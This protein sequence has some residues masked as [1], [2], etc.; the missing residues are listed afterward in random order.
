MKRDRRLSILYEDDE[1]LVVD[2]PAGVLTIPSHPTRAPYEDTVLR[3]VREYVSR[4]R[5][6]RPYVGVLHRLDRDTSGALAL[7]L[8]REAH[9]AG[10]ALFSAHQFERHYLAIVHGVPAPEKGTIRAPISSRYISGRRGVARPGRDARDAVTH[11]TVLED[12]GRVSLVA[13]ELGTGRQHQIRAHLEHLGHPLLGERVYSGEGKARIKAPRQML[14]AW[15]L[16]F[17]HPLRSVTIDVEADP[18]SDFLTVLSRYHTRST[19][20]K[21]SPRRREEHEEE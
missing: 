7:A 2:K 18:P 9:E 17:A 1:I 3:R 4:P 14:H 13:L 12:L 6:P 8:S 10:R 21:S 11:Y 16:K 15:K 5:G 20:A 19:P